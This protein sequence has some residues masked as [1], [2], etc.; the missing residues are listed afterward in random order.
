MDST[1]K[2]RSNPRCLLTELSDGTGVILHLDTKFYF[3]INDTG[4]FLWKELTRVPQSA[5]E[6]ATRMSDEYA[7]SEDA[8]LTDVQA[9]LVEL[10]AN[11]LIDPA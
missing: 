3:S 11:R 2:V 7:V 10:D 8:A 1:A 6:L 4:V 5:R 9:L